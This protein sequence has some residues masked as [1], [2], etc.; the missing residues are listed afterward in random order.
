[1]KT[2][3]VYINGMEVGMVKAGSHKAAEK[4]V[5]RLVSRARN[6]TNP[7]GSICPTPKRDISVAYTEL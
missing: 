4:K 6:L 2:Y 1:M 5:Q 7:D 3:I